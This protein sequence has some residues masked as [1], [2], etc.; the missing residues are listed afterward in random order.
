MY[1]PI[2]PG[3][4][5]RVDQGQH[6][7]GGMLKQRT[8]L[9]LLI[10]FKAEFQG[11]PS[12]GD[13]AAIQAR[14]HT[15]PSWTNNSLNKRLII[16][17]FNLASFDITCASKTFGAAMNIYVQVQVQPILRDQGSHR[18]ELPHPVFSPGP[19]RQTLDKRQMSDI[20]EID[21]CVH[22]AMHTVCSFSCAGEK[23]SYGLHS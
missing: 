4:R 16:I 23:Y 10:D 3:N 19:P 18:H 9:E 5:T 15:H 20:L 6:W 17:T 13:L 11:H 8:R 22:C 7:F 12:L 2:L 21:L 14:H 1:L